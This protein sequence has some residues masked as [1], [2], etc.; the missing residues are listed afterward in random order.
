VAAQKA[1][2]VADIGLGLFGTGLEP[3][4]ANLRGIPLFGDL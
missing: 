4:C 1:S 3:I 2:P